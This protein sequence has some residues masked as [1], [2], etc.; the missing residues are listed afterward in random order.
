MITTANISDQILSRIY[1][2]M[3][4]PSEVMKLYFKECGDWFMITIHSV[5]PEHSE[6]QMWEC[7]SVRVDIFDRYW[8]ELAFVGIEKQVTEW[9][10]IVASRPVTRNEMFNLN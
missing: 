9:L 10:N 4:D 6:S 5:S 3:P 7:A 2:E 8:H 1:L